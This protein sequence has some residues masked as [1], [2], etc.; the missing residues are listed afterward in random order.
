MFFLI[1]CYIYIQLK[2]GMFTFT[3]AVVQIMR[4]ACEQVI[5]VSQNLRLQFQAV[6]FFSWYEIKKI[7]YR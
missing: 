7:G 6:F 2:L 1:F 4:S 3:K 5:H